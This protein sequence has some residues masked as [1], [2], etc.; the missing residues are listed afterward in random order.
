MTQE[1]MVEQ[2][3]DLYGKYVKLTDQYFMIVRKLSEIEWQY[4]QI[5]KK[6]GIEVIQ[7]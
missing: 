4:E 6:N 5:M 2:M 1:E 3:F 7:Q